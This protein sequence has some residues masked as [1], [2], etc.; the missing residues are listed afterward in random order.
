MVAMGISSLRKSEGRVIWRVYDA[1][2][3]LDSSEMASSWGHITG[4]DQDVDSVYMETLSKT[5]DSVQDRTIE[6]GTALS[7]KRFPFKTKGIC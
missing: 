7:Q 6:G 1:G 5:T 4:G 2:Y 3:L